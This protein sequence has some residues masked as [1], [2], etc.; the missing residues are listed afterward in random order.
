[1]PEHHGCSFG[2]GDYVIE[3][4]STAGLDQRRTLVAIRVTQ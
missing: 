1:M 2:G 4:T 3:L